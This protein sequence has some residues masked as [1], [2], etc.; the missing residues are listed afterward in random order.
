MP[1]CKGRKLEG[2]FWNKE[3]VQ[4]IGD[5]C[6]ARYSSSFTCR[7]MSYLM[8]FL[9]LHAAEMISYA[10]S[11]DWG[12]I[13]CIYCII[14]SCFTCYFYGLLIASE[15]ELLCMILRSYMPFLS[16]PSVGHVVE[17]SF[18]RLLHSFHHFLVIFLRHDFEIRVRTIFYILYFHLIMR[19]LLSNSD[20]LHIADFELIVRAL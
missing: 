6:E 3:D 5:I 18:Q 17:C 15:F 7:F 19:S 12:L 8:I 14:R 2:Y 9:A 16:Y 1:K 4:L 13:L 10:Y 11:S 20:F